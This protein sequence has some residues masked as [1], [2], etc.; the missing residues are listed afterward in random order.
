M[1]Q[2]RIGKNVLCLEVEPPGIAEFVM[3]AVVVPIT[4]PL[5]FAM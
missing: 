5:T 2:A 4:I 1:L 3:G